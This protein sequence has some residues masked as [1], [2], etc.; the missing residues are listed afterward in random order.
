MELSSQE[1]DLTALQFVSL[2]KIFSLMAAPLLQA[3]RTLARDP[4]DSVFIMTS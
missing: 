4:K 3:W 1:I 2:G